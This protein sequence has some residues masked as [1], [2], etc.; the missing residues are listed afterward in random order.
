MSG[1]KWKAWVA[2]TAVLVALY[3]LTL[4]VNPEL[5][6][7]GIGATIVGAIAF[8]GVGYGGV[9]V[10]DSWQRAKYYRPELDKSVAE[11]EK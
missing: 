1:R 11:E 7:S 5:L 3:I 6:A 9:Q 2:T 8:G 4:L 10:A